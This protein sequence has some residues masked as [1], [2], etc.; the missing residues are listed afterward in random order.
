MRQTVTFS[1]DT[2]KDRDLARWLDSLPAGGRSE[3]IREALRAGLGRGGVSLGD[4][5][6]A[7]K[8]LDRKLQNGVSVAHASD[9]DTADEPADAAAALDKL[10]L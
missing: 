7:V 10:G 5:Y 9:D 6:Q 1:L 3:A 4:V 8:E 2:D